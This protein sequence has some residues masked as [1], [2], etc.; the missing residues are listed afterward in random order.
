MTTHMQQQNKANNN[1]NKP[2]GPIPTTSVIV[3]SP[4][5]INRVLALWTHFFG[6]LFSDSGHYDHFGTHPSQTGDGPGR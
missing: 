6:I 2:Q 1:Y 4:K 3:T 5:D